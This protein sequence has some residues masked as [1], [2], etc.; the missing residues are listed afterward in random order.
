LVNDIFELVMKHV[1]FGL[2]DGSMFQGAA[3]SVLMLARQVEVL[4]AGR[5]R[6]DVGSRDVLNILFVGIRDTCNNKNSIS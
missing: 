4:P 6:D 5:R 1:V 2:V 3:Y